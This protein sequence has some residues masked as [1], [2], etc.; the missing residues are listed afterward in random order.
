METAETIARRNQA[1]FRERVAARIVERR[2]KI[3]DIAVISGGVV[4]GLTCALF[5]WYIFMN[6]DKFG[7]PSIPFDTAK[8]EADGFVPSRTATPQMPRGY[9]NYR[10]VG[11]PK[12]DL[13]MEPTGSVLQAFHGAVPNQPFPEAAA[14]FKVVHVTAGRAMIQDDTGIWLVQRGSKLPDGSRVEKIEQRGRKWVVV[15]TGGKLLE[16]E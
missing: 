9:D 4:L 6:P 12:H 2:V 11:L 5:P 10:I 3:A 1:S 16:G 15:A 13:D 8:V 7:P 14:P